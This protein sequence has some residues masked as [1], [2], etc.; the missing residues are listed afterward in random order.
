MRI[1][2]FDSMEAPKLYLVYFEL[3]KTDSGNILK[4]LLMT[5]YRDLNCV[6]NFVETRTHI[7]FA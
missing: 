6:I 4:I 2:I 7:G 3:I 5:F 1:I